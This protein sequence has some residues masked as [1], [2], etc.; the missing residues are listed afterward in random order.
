MSPPHPPRLILNGNG[1]GL[2]IGE[3]GREMKPWTQT[4]YSVI[5]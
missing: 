3:T 2:D 5:K 4:V 1:A